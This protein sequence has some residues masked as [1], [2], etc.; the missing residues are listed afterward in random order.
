MKKRLYILIFIITI[1]CSLTGCP[2]NSENAGVK[3]NAATD[4]INEILPMYVEANK[5]LNGYIET[6]GKVVEDESGKAYKK[7]V[8]DKYKS[9]DDIKNLLNSVF[10]AEYIDK[11][12]NKIFERDY[13]AFKEIEGQLYVAVMSGMIKPLSSNPIEEINNIEKDSFSV[14]VKFGGGESGPESKSTF[15]FIN[16]NNKWLINNI[17]NYNEPIN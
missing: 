14:V 9:V 4:V 7:V 2:E 11:K 3:L 16:Q 1:L 17:E 15:Y 6:E 13:P 10:A 12:Y 8:S 5:I